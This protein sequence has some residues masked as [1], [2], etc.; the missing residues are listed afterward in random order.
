MEASAANVP[1][2]PMVNKMNPNH[3]P[4]TV[5]PPSNVPDPTDRFYDKE[6]ARLAAE[7]KAD[8]KNASV[9]ASKKRKRPVKPTLQELR[10]RALKNKSVET[11]TQ[12]T[13]PRKKRSTGASATP[14]SP[15]VSPPANPPSSEWLRALSRA[16]R[17]TKMAMRQFKI[18]GA[19]GGMIRFDRWEGVARKQFE[20]LYALALAS[21]RIM[22]DLCERLQAVFGRAPSGESKMSIQICQSLGW[23]TL[24]SV[25]EFQS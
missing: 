7:Q 4:V 2:K 10:N 16:R 20:E 23:L 5:G 21:D 15:S 25:G 18:G 6:E 11:T 12:D 1:M 19:H 24:H 14:V 3:E 9:G 13:V 22:Y 17:D 8:S